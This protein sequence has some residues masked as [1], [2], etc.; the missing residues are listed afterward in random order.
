MRNQSK[1]T[2]RIKFDQKKRKTNMR[3]THLNKD[4]INQNPIKQSREKGARATW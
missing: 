1:L 4:A 2:H 3:S